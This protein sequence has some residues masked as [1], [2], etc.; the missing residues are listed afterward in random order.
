MK[1]EVKMGQDKTSAHESQR[2][3]AGCSTH[4]RILSCRQI[5][6]IRSNHDSG[7]EKPL[8]LLFGWDG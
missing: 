5:Y 6:F 1:F 8:N 4:S 2:N 3:N 7:S